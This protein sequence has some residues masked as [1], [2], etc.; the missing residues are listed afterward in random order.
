[1]NLYWSI[2]GKFKF[3]TL[4]NNLVTRRNFFY[5]TQIKKMGYDAQCILLVHLKNTKSKN[6]FYFYLITFLCLRLITF[7]FKSDNHFSLA[8]SIKIRFHMV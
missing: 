5:K 2:L 8:K 6:L 7:L 3:K 1:M 4:K